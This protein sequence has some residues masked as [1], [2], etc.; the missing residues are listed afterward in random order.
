MPFAL[1]SNVENPATN[2]LD[3]NF[4]DTAILQKFSDF[5][6]NLCF[7]HAFDFD[8]FNVLVSHIATLSIISFPVKC[9]KD[10]AKMETLWFEHPLLYDL[11]AIR[12]MG[13][14]SFF[15]EGYVSCRCK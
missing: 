6:W 4:L 12:Q 8:C 14:A 10:Y 1:A 5:D 13:E 9:N 7:F 11:C 15:L 2:M 3:G